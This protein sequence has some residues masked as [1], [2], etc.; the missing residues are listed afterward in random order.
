MKVILVVG[1]WVYCSIIGSVNVRRHGETTLKGSA[2]H[3]ST[4]PPPLR[5]SGKYQLRTFLQTLQSTVYSPTNPKFLAL[6]HT[7][8]ASY[9]QL[10]ARNGHAQI[11][12]MGDPHPS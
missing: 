6:A 3:R 8:A 5:T 2:A 11:Q 10:T 7:E 4:T 1:E 9:A 12:Q